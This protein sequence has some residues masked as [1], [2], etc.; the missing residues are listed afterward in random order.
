MKRT[1]TTLLLCLILGA[2]AFAQGG[3]DKK[4]ADSK[5]ADA[6]SVDQILNKY[7]EASGGKAAIEKQTSRMAKGT[8]EIPAMGASGTAEVYEK[9]PNK[10]LIVIT[11]PGFG[12]V[13]EGFNGTVA[14]SQNPQEGL[15][16][17]SGQELADTK[18]DAEFYKTLKLKQLYPKITFKGKEK[19]GDKEAYHLEA[20]PAEGSTEQWY[21]DAASG[22]LIRSDSERETPQGK[23]PVKTFM[24]DYRDVNGVKM[25]FSMRQ[26]LPMFTLTIKI[27]EVKPN[28]PIDDAKFNKPS[29]Q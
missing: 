11:I 8:F 6:P 10:S 7:V 17:K 2:S 25:P 24:E 23:M 13:Q 12:V 29:G 9:A 26:E 20:T 14:W 28:V 27:D 16:E 4:P 21:F 3:Q 15:R 18:L 5:P 22:L 19:V 1:L